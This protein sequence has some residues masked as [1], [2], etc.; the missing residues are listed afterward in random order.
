MRQFSIAALP[1][2]CAGPF[3]HSRFFP[4]AQHFGWQQ[5]GLSLQQ[6]SIS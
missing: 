1:F 6:H 4:A 3:W 5:R 2:F